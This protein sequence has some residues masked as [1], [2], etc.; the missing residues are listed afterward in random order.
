VDV[1]V[2]VSEWGER[3]LRSR[4]KKKRMKRGMRRR[5]ITQM[6]C[7]ARRGAEPMAIEPTN[8]SITDVNVTVS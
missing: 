3:N 2:C 8:E 1:E 5:S 4:K 6:S 7:V